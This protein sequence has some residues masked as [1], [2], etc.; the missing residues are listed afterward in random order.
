[1]GRRTSRQLSKA[2]Q[3]LMEEQTESL[4]KEAFGGLSPEELKEQEE[5]LK[6][7]REVSADFLAALEREALGQGQ[8]KQGRSRRDHEG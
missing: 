8:G 6:R 5:R 3:R 1:M 7:I 4:K 2:L